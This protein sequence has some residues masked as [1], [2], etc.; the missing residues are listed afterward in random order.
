[1]VSF[2]Y[3]SCNTCKYRQFSAPGLVCE[4]VS[5]VLS[6]PQEN[7]VAFEA[8]HVEEA[9]VGKSAGPYIPCWR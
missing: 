1:M 6:C 9:H 8:A 3:F 7:L 2:R 4:Y 5:A